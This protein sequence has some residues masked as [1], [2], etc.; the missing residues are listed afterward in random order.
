MKNQRVIRGRITDEQA[1]KR[2]TLPTDP[3]AY[4][5]TALVGTDDGG[6]HEQRQGEGYHGGADAERY[7]RMFLQSV[8][9]DY[10]IGYQRV[11]GEYAGQQQRRLGRIA[12]KPHARAVGHDE[13]H[14]EGQQTENHEL[15]PP[16]HDVLQVHLQSGEE[17][18]VEHAHLPE[19]LEGG[20]P[21]ENVE[22][23]AADGDARQHHTY[24]MRYAQASHDDRGEKDDA[25]HDKEYQCR[26]GYREI[27]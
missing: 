22:P 2:T 4:V 7:A 23:V 16:P 15:E 12:Q 18:D 24:Y 19:E 20:V 5:R 17:H 11:C 3:E 21:L 13:R 10:G 1:Q 14:G 27:M 26:V 25:E 6:Q 8:A 9:T